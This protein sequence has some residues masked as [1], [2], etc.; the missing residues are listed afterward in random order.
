VAIERRC[1]GVPAELATAQ[2]ER[3]RDRAATVRVAVSAADPSRVAVI[4]NPISGA[5]GRPTAGLKRAALAE[6]V[7]AAEGHEGS[8]TVTTGPGHA[9]ALARAAVAEGAGLAVAWGG[10]GT[11]NEVA[12]A[13]AFGPV[14]LGIVPAGSGNGLARDLGLP[15]DPAAALR[16]ALRGVERRI[17]VG[18][19]G[20]RLFVTTAGIGLDAEIARRFNARALGRRGLIPYWTLAART[21]W[22]YEP[23]LYTL[24]VDGARLETRALLI[25][26]ANARQYGGRAVIAPAARVDDGWLDLVVVEARSLWATGWHARRLFTGSLAQAPGICMRRYRELVVQAPAPLTFHVDAEPVAGGAW[27][28]GR[29]HPGALRIRVPAG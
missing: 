25:T 2:V 3:L 6:R 1:R 14:A 4:V 5:R 28:T 8:V 27:L 20:G 12:S 10:D 17:D 9:A 26:C 18:E 23:G 19:L 22:R 13:L 11:V 15:R 29:V 7:V 24:E 16:A 21:L